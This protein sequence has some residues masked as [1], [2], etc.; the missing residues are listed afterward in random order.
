MFKLKK[1][2]DMKNCYYYSDKVDFEKPQILF[3][4]E[5][6]N[7][8]LLALYMIAYYNVFIDDIDYNF[9]MSAMVQDNRLIVH[10]IFV[11][12]DRLYSNFIDSVGEKIEEAEKSLA[13]LSRSVK[14]FENYTDKDLIE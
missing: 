4:F 1:V 2:D 10:L 7:K 8:D 11:I 5:F 9:N 6:A 14:T 13:S 3:V 12:N